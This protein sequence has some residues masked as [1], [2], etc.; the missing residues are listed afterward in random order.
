MSA[1]RDAL[2]MEWKYTLP[3]NRKWQEHVSHDG[4]LH[5]MEICTSWWWD[6]VSHDGAANEMEICTS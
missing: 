6:C 2:L 1:E 5:E 4:A 3:N